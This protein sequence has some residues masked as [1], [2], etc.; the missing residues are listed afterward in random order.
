MKAFP[1]PRS[2]RS[3]VPTSAGCLVTRRG[4][5]GVEVL[6]V[7]PTRATFRRPLFGIPKGMVDP[8]ETPEQAALRE[9]MEETGLEVRILA[10]LGTVEQKSGKIVHAYLAEIEPAS[11]ALV[12]A[13]GRCTAPDGEND[14]CRF[15]PIPKALQVMLPAQRPFIQRLRELLPDAE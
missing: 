14:V 1:P 3:K 11:L 2:S 7:H 13:L 6:L 4:T 15:F 5:S 10:S 12:D 9:T 8:G